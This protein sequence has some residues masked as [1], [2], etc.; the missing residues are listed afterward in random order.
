MA[1]TL[2][3]KQKK[4][5]EVLFTQANGDYLEAKRLAGYSE[6]TATSEV[7]AGLREEILSKTE[8]FIGLSSAKAAYTLF[9]VMNNPNELG[10][11]ERTVA[12][13]DFL[14]R[15][16]FKPKEKVEVSAPNPLFILPAKANEEK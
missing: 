10:N 3:D 8:E 13:K 6:N 1:K 5:L 11:R 9:D 4:F 14:D 7:V 2:T 16:G 12:A 15:A